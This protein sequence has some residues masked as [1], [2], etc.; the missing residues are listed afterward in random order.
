MVP[1]YGLL[2]FGGE[3]KIKHEKQTI[4]LDNWLEFD[5]P[6]RISVLI[7][8]LRS[9]VTSLLTEKIRNPALDISRSMVATALMQ[10]LVTDGR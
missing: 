1:A 9:M 6:A 3:V 5:S 2:L 8:E 7:K 10:M 4:M